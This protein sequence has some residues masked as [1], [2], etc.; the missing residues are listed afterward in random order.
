MKTGNLNKIGIAATLV[1]T[2]SIQ[3]P[4]AFGQGSL[5]PPGPPA[6]TMKS[7]D[8][9]E[10][11]MPVSVLP[12][13]IT[14]AGSYYLTTNLAGISGA[15]GINIATNQ[16]TLDL[17]GFIL[18]GVPGSLDCIQVVGDRTNI[19]VRNG[20]ITGWGGNGVNASAYNLTCEELTIGPCAG[21]GIACPYPGARVSRCT[22]RSCYWGID[23]SFGS[24][25][26]CI[27]S[28]SAYI[29]IHSGNGAV[30]HCVVQFCGLSG[31]L[32][33]SSTVSGC[34]VSSNS[35]SGIFVG[36]SDCLVSGNQCV[37][38]NLGGS[39]THAGIYIQSNDNRIEENHL[40]DN[41][42]A[43]IQL[44][45]LGSYSNNIVVKNSVSGNGVNNYLISGNQAV[46]PLITTYGTITNA[47]PW[48]NFSF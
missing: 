36:G 22:V 28:S 9:I 39:A 48:A 45:N 24:V 42:Y 11:R 40:T 43:G 20:T 25:M 17:N 41:G 12:F 44:N 4:S 46:G 16:V 23:L 2:F 38:N 27:V 26:D 32:V 29:G 30:S 10:P 15:N 34:F 19:T 21:S 3:L 13:T 5:T 18:K 33:A 37:A 35:A 6:P 7:L 14:N 31:I 1:L 8:Q 47:N